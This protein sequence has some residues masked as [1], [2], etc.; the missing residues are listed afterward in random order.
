[1]NP[2]P[3][4][5]SRVRH[6]PESATMKIADTAA[7]LRSEG[8]DIISFSLGEPDFETPENI[9]KAAKTALDRGETHY[10]QGSGIPE[11]REA[12]AERLKNEN[13]LDVS[14]ADVLV[15]PGAKQAIFE[16]ICTLIDERD[17][18][19]LLD[20]AWVSYSAIVKFA[21][22]K[23]VMVPVSE[24]DG[25]VPVDL[26]SHMTRD[27][28]LLI[29]NSPCNP[30][31]AVY[32]KNAIK[33]AAET[34]EDHGVFVLSDEVYE[35]I[36]YGAQHHSIGSLIPD[37]T[38]T[39]NGF[40]KA[41]AMT[42]WRL[43]Y[44]TAP[45]PILQGMLKIQ[46]HS[47]SHATSFAQRA[48]VEALRGDQG[49]MRAMVAEFKKRRDIMIDGLRKMGIECALPRGA[50]Y[51]FANVSQFGNSVEVTEKLLQDALVAVTPGSAFGPNGEGHVRLSYAAS[52]QNIED[53]INRIGASLAQA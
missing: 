29:L 33:T 49:A 48:G 13:N 30:T 16:A 27:T 31:G 22:G 36:I 37:R 12:I 15:T 42:G 21:G 3:V 46:Q 44:A 14:P 19:L 40:S 5:S 17:E 6:I 28:K 24:Q 34:A 39:I 53:G 50:F 20:P 10:T 51:A 43:G 23:P 32:G 52:R 1:M 35:K 2:N 47:V 41:Y 11:L 26:Q 18:V 25:Y 38:I 9:K 7:K 45:A 4:I 8:R